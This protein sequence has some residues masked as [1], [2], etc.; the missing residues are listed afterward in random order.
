MAPATGA[1]VKTSI[2]QQTTSSYPALAGRASCPSRSSLSQTQSSSP[3]TPLA[4]TTRLL[5]ILKARGRSR[6][7]AFF[8]ETPIVKASTQ[9]ISDAARVLHQLGL[10]DNVLL[11]AR[12]HGAAHDA[13]SAPLGVWR[14]VRVREDRGPPRFVAW[15]PL[16]RRVVAKKGR[17]DGQPVGA[18]P[19]EISP[20]TA[21]PGADDRPS[22]DPTPQNADIPDPERRDG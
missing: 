16:P 17:V 15:E 2:L 6:F 12:H 9:P 11:V 7:D 20:S 3:G 1:Q 13:I 21:P 8:G 10:P 5:I 18:T 4:E 19:D 14:K 22:A